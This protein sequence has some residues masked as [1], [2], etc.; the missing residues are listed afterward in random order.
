MSDSD[1]LK[2]SCTHCQ[3]HLEF[4]AHAL[5]I[6]TTCPHCGVETT[7]VA[8]TSTSAPPPPPP[9]PPQ[10]TA[11]PLAPAP[12]LATITPVDASSGGSKFKKAV[13]LVSS[14]IA[15]LVVFG[16]VSLKAWKYFR[17]AGEAVEAVKVEPK[18]EASKP[19]SEVPKLAPMPAPFAPATSVVLVKGTPTT[20]KAGE[21]LQVLSFEVQKAKDGNLQYIVGVVTNHAAKQYFNVKLEFELTRKDGK[22][23][24]RATDTIRNL[25][26]NAGVTFKASVIGNTAV[27]TAKLAKLEGEKE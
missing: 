17:R 14:V 18:T 7:L 25:A 8:P 22:A 27:A 4:P 19:A 12:A 21:D 9:P 2:C 10:P 15:G 5:G 3:G 16:L 24:D 26:P 20:R 11:P 23:G 1:Y 6:T 13:S